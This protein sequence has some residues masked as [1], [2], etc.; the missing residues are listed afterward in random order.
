MLLRAIPRVV[1]CHFISESPKNPKLMKSNSLFMFTLLAVSF[2]GGAVY[3]IQKMAAYDEALQQAYKELEQ[4]ELAHES[5]KLEL[6]QAIFDLQREEEAHRL[7]AFERD[8]IA[9]VL[10]DT[11]IALTSKLDA[12]ERARKED[13]EA[14]KQ[15]VKDAYN[16]GLEDGREALQ[17]SL[18]NLHAANAQIKAS[19]IYGIT[20]LSSI[21]EED[22]SYPRSVEDI[23]KMDPDSQIGLY[24]AG[25][26]VLLW[27]IAIV[28]R[29]WLN[30]YSLRRI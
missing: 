7:T 29:K 1:I 14:A 18:R 12:S 9:K 15:R 25:I 20:A 5:T 26:T 3:H 24:L 6:G 30:R 21:T 4:E 2:G 27:I 23:S 8:S 13:A 16:K 10:R 17:D 11:V 19:S 22:V 28:M